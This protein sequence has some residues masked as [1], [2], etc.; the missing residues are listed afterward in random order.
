MDVIFLDP[1]AKDL[2]GSVA[3]GEDELDQPGGLLLG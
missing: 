3:L 1:V 2:G